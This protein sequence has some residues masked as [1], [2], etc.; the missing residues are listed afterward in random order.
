MSRLLFVALTLLVA[1][2][3]PATVNAGLQKE[4][5]KESKAREAPP[6]QKAAQPLSPSERQQG[7][8]EL[9][10]LWAETQKLRKPTSWFPT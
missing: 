7:L 9:R 6:A 8:R 1:C 10:R 2:V 5:P 4:E 3:R